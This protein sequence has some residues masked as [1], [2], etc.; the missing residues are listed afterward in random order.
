MKPVSALL[1]CATIL[2]VLVFASP[3]LAS[4]TGVM[5]TTMTNPSG[6]PLHHPLQRRGK[7]W[8]SFKS[9]IKKVAKVASFLI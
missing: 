7:L 4:P 8:D 9:G 5:D 1:N 2:V 3:V 6:S